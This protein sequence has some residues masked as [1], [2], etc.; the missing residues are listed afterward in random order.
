MCEANAQNVGPHC[1][2][3]LCVTYQLRERERE[4]LIYLDLET[5]SMCE[6]LTTWNY[7]R[8]FYDEK[9]INSVLID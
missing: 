4:R 2:I 8:C 1:R 6:I 9:A 7:Y 3:E 5:C